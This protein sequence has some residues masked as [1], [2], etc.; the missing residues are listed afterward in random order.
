MFLNVLKKLYILLSN[1]QKLTFLIILMCM[2]ISA[3]LTQITPLIIGKITDHLTQTL[4]FLAIIPALMAIL[5]VM[6]TNEILKIVRRLSVE[7]VVTSVEVLARKKVTQS[8]L[9][10][11]LSYFNQNM[12]GRIYSKI[13]HSLEGILRL[14]KLLFMDFVPSILTSL[15]AIVIIFIKMP[16]ILACVTVLVIPIGTF[17]ILRQIMSQKGIR[18]KLLEERVQIDAYIVELINGIE[19]VR[20]M[21]T[22]RQEINRCEKKSENLRKQLMHH[23]YKMGM[24]DFLK[25]LNEAVFNVIVLSSAVYLASIKAISVGGVLTAYLCFLEL[26]R[27][28][29]ELHRILDELSENTLL[30]HEYFSL[31]EIKPDF[32]YQTVK[33]ADIKTQAVVLK[34]VTFKYTDSKKQPVLQHFSLTIKPHSFIGFVGRSG[35]G[36]STLI[37]LIL[38]LEQ[39][40]NGHIYINRKDI[41]SLSRSEIADTISLVP[42]TP[43]LIADTIFN[44][45]AYGMKGHISLKQIQEAAKKAEIHSDILKL[46]NQ[47][48][49]LLSEGGK[50]L[51]GGQRQRIALARIFLKKPKILILDEA[52]SALDNITEKKVQKEIEDMAKKYQMTVIVIAHR[53]STLVNCDT[54]FVMQDGAIIEQGNYQELL[55]KKQVF[56]SMTQSKINQ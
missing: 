12:T 51:S 1:K 8:L 20:V 43:F 53:L 16:F 31:M 23:H 22:E 17:I 47:Y 49:H 54:I 10:A 40:K 32:S 45:I 46:E 37:K 14:L 6:V 28:L 13:N 3:V 55:K 24:F 34:D 33:K 44:N 35:C 25:F 29:R 9:L 19:T 21:N 27:P 50:N 42:Q 48:N 41:L 15:A 39:V 4:N 2:G 36:K 52:T 26:L 5:C 56:F 30:A 11:H 18:L 38:K 7:N